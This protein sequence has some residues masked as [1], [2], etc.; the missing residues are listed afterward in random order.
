VTGREL[1]LNQG[2]H[3]VGSASWKR[4]SVPY[5]STGQPGRPDVRAT[6][7]RGCCRRALGRARGCRRRSAACRYT[8]R[9]TSAQG[10]TIWNTWN[11]P[12]TSCAC[13]GTPASRSRP[14]NRR[15]GSR[16]ISSAPRDMHA[17]GNPSRSACIF[18]GHWCSVSLLAGTNFVTCVPPEPLRQSI[19][20]LCSRSLSNRTRRRA[21]TFKYAP[22]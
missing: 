21:A 13:V 4:P 2:A 7:H 19:D 15:I 14:A 12:G 1:A 10:I 6:G 16:N 8:S 9:L 22:W 18:L 17:G 20:A 11:M 3:P 5:I